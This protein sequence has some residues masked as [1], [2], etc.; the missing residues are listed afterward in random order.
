MKKILTPKA[1]YLFLL[2]GACFLLHSIRD[3]FQYLRKDNIL[4]R[5][6]NHELSVKFTNFLLATFG[7]KYDVSQEV[8]YF[9]LELLI[10]I[11]LFGLFIYFLT[12]NAR[13]ERYGPPTN[14]RP[15][16]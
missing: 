10:S 3:L 12:K 13:H 11:L 1:Y 7:L 8:Y 9:F 2:L 14:P 15:K 5:V 4:T 6:G 16:S